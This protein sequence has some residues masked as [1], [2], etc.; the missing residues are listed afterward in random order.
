MASEVVGRGVHTAKGK[1][2]AVAVAVAVDVRRQRAGK[3]SAW[4]W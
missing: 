4:E 2:V 3:K 1:D